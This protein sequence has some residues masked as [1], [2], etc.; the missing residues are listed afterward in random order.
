MDR[1][2]APQAVIAAGILLVGFPPAVEHAPG[3]SAGPDRRAGADAGST[4][5]EQP[6]PLARDAVHRPGGVEPVGRRKAVA[7]AVI[8]PAADDDVAGTPPGRTGRRRHRR[9]QR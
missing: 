4:D 2:A 3:P 7:A 1:D 9:W 5:V 8:P 6:V